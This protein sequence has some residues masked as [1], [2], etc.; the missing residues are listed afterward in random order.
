MWSAFQ[1]TLTSFEPI[2]MPREYS[3]LKRMCL[4]RVRRWAVWSVRALGAQFR[5]EIEEG[6]LG[7]PLKEKQ[8]VVG[9]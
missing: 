9:G 1:G 2:K 8:K 3:Q 5:A 7:W 6:G 4:T